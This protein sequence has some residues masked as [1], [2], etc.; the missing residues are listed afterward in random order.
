MHIPC[1]VWIDEHHLPPGIIWPGRSGHNI[2]IQVH[3]QVVVL[4]GLIQAAQG[5]NMLQLSAKKRSGARTKHVL[6]LMELVP[7]PSQQPCL[8]PVKLKQPFNFNPD[9]P[10]EI[11]LPDGYGA[12]EIEHELEKLGH[13][14]HAYPMEGTGTAVIVPADWKQENDVRRISFTAQFKTR[15]LN[16]KMSFC[17]AL[18]NQLMSFCIL[19]DVA[20]NLTS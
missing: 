17:I 8:V 6:S 18:E 12:Q 9:M 11:F 16:S 4:P 7:E 2:V 3:R 5:L 15:L 14:T 13:N 19:A 20:T 1:Q 10:S